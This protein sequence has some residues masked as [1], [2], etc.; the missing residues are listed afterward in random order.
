MGMDVASD[1][2]DAGGIGQDGFDELH[3]NSGIGF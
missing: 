1:G 3:A 2:G